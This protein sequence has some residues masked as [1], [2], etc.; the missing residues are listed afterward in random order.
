[1]SVKALTEQI[2]RKIS[3][4]N[5]W[6]YR[7]MLHLFP[8]WLAVRGR[9]NFTNL[10]RWGE[11]GEDTYRQNFARPFSWLEF[12]AELASQQLGQHL[13]IAFDPCFVPK[14][15]K[16]T[17]GIG[18]F[19]SG[20]AGRELRGLEFSGIA[21]VDLADKAALHLE[22]VQ[23]VG[24]KEGESQ[25]AFYARILCE[26][27]EALLRL[28]K[29]VAADAY[30]AREPFVDTLLGEGVQLITR[31]RKDA[32][33]RYLYNGP[34]LK[35][36]RGRPKTYD[37][38]I[39]PY[40][41]REDHFTPCAQAEDGSWAA[42]QST[43][44]VQ[45]WK[46]NA[47]VVIVHHLDDQGQVKSA[48]IYACTDTGMD[49]AEVLHA[50]QCRFQIEFLYRDGKQHAGLAHCQARS[51]QKLHFHLNTAL[52]AVS[53]AKAA[54]C[55]STPPQERKAFSMAD[56]KTQYANDLLLDRFIATFGIGAQLSKINS[57]RERFRAIGKIAA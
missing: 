4:N 25:L 14:S 36:R 38:R 49:G 30:F 35:R 21:A 6:Q 10:S 45:S 47:K 5:R 39:N 20:C 50:Y 37:G 53:L 18:Y 17:A 31:L 42:Y 16:H 52:T 11:Y 13:A 26:R 7:F 46:R 55:L 23:T 43:V 48:K 28:S 33:L 54:Y 22:A 51:P 32:R 15:G 29:Y 2:L 34:R 9:Y 56:V 57:I 8:L 41:L 12:N 3:T 27:K 1:M 40:A 24:L 44:N 19:Y